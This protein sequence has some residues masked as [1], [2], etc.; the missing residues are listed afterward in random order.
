METVSI[1][2]LANLP[3]S[4][5]ATL[6]SAQEEAARV[7]NDVRAVHRKAREAG[8]SWPRRGELQAHT[9]GRFALHS[10]SVQMVCH[11][12]LANVEATTARR[13]SEPGCRRWLRYPWKEKRFMTVSWPRQAVSYDAT[14]RRLVLPM[15]R[16]RKSVVLRLDLDYEPGAVN[17]VWN[18]GT[19][20]LHV[21]RSDVKLA[22]E[23]PGTNR[24][25]VDLGEIHLG[26]VVTDTGKA[27]VV[28][29]RAIR[30]QKRLLSKQNGEIARKRSRCT[31]EV[32]TH[33]E[34][35]VPPR[36]ERVGGG[37]LDR[38]RRGGRG[39]AVGIPQGDGERA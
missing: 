15:G 10:Q 12:F 11:Q 17:L 3:K 26:A 6:S 2:R 19:Y 4:V 13:R 38:E 22:E 34:V 20:E 31:E 16:G 18:E 24:A 36:Q 32:L 9:K 37:R 25:T 7:W 39:L 29:G 33:A 23:P 30:S 28:T 14:A 1:Q 27:M 5:Q 21:V 8:G 35:E